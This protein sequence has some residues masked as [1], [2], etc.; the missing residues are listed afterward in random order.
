MGEGEMTAPIKP[1]WFGITDLKEPVWGEGVLIGCFSLVGVQPLATAA[2]R[3]PVA[4]AGSGRVG[5]RTVIGCHAT[6][7]A[8]VFMGEDCRVGDFAT[9]R[10]DCRIGARCVIGTNADLQYGCLLGD[11]VRVLNGT[12][13]SGGTVIGSG[14]FIGPGVMTANDRQLDVF[15]YVDH[16]NRAAPI[17]GK[18]VF[19][20]VG[21]IILPGVTIG[22]G[23]RVGAGSLVTRDVAAGAT[24]Y[25]VPARAVDK[26]GRLRSTPLEQMEGR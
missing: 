19:V 8:G 16:P 21:A 9:I 2:N 22:D 1:T 25:G 7:Y 20:G 10:E 26:S 18:N 23:A 4:K 6:I 3:R 11:D 14:S 5:A 17:I 15:N 24:V 13:I 12:H